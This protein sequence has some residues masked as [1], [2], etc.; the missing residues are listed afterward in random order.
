MTVVPAATVLAN[1]WMGSYP[2]GPWGPAGLP[3][4]P[5]FVAAYDPRIG[6]LYVPLYGIDHLGVINDT[7]N[8]LVE[9]FHT[10]DDPLW[11]TYDP[12]NG[13]IYDTNWGNSTASIVNNTTVIATVQVGNAP[14]S[15]V[16][17]SVNGYVYVVARNGSGAGDVAVLDGESVLAQVTVGTSPAFAT[18]DS[19]TGYVYVFNDVSNNVSVIDGTSLI[20]TIYLGAGSI[21][22]DG[23]FDPDDGDVYVADTGTNNVSLLRGTSFVA[24]VTL[25]S[26][27]YSGAYDPATGDVYMANP[28]LACVSVIHDRSVVGNVSALND[29]SYVTYD[30]ANGQLYVSSPSGSAITVVQGTTAVATVTLG[31]GYLSQMITYDSGNG[32]LYI[33]DEGNGSTSVLGPPN[34][35]YPVTF[36]EKGLPAGTNWSVDVATASQLS[37]GSST[38]YTPPTPSVEFG[39]SNGTYAYAVTPIPGYYA[40]NGSGNVTINGTSEAVTVTFEPTYEVEFL[41]SGLPDGTSWN[42]TIGPTRV[43]STSDNLSFQEPN[44]SF[45]YRVD[46]VPGYRTSATTGSVQVYGRATSVSLDFATTVYDVVFTEAGLPTGTPWQ[47]VLSGRP[48]AAAGDMVI[49]AEANGTYD[50]S[51]SAGP[52]YFTAA[53][54]GRVTVLSGP[55]HVNLS[56]VRA[57]PVVFHEHGLPNDTNWSVTVGEQT[58][59]STLDVIVLDLPNGSQSYDVGPEAGYSTAWTGSI[60]VTGAG[61]SV[62]V[63]FVVTQFEVSFDEVGLPGGVEWGVVFDGTPE[64]STGGSVTFAAANGTYPYSIEPVAG[65]IASVR[66]GTLPVDDAA[67]SVNVTFLRTYPVTFRE[68]GPRRRDRLDRH[69]RTRHELLDIH[70]P[71][72]RRAERDPPVLGHADPRVHRLLDRN[73]PSRRRAGEREP[74]VR[75]RPLPAHLPG[76]RAAVPHPLAGVDRPYDERIE[77]NDD[78][79]RRAERLVLLA[80][81]DRR[82]LPPRHRLGDGHA[83]RERIHRC[84]RLLRDHVHRPVPGVGTSR[85][86]PVERAS[87]GDA[88]ERRNR[89][90]LPPARQRD[91]RLQCPT[92]GRVRHA[93]PGQRDRVRGLAPRHPRLV[94]EAGERQRSDPIGVVCHRRGCRCGRRR[95]RRARPPH[96]APTANGPDRAG[97][98]ARSGVTERPPR[99]EWARVHGAG[100]GPR[101]RVYPSPRAGNGA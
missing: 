23:T 50:Y 53:E 97:D 93:E 56:F 19:V 72:P 36:T 27:P 12:Q 79:L 67:V 20:G 74:D 90:H 43:G 32:D 95:D 71:R 55:S 94:R 68:T 45:E 54:F 89:D 13:Y 46:F 35:S 70:D 101:A 88:A 1:V 24:N 37:N 8:T 59:A 60:T 18:Y 61:R 5:K 49:F 83:R 69:G 38:L 100:R 99:V 58:N 41:E 31:S 92:G 17:D 16:Y 28:G 25:N 57:Y 47:V 80:R 44:G 6:D 63:T 21:P 85:R 2:A 42:V 11:A 82:G 33:P 87:G 48:L 34:D 81:R 39:E 22:L 64:S 51:A 96:E 62:N 14:F 65:W 26:T 7:T 29:S 30:P 78:R 40:A 84:D 66:A 91:V 10:S 86:D 52:G 15:S 73:L 3:T 76:G 77:R 75:R 4:Y 98:G 9:G